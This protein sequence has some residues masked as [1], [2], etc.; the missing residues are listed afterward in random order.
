MMPKCLFNILHRYLA[1]HL[2]QAGTAVFAGDAGDP[3]DQATEVI[4]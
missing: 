3:V 2:L 4:F 1:V